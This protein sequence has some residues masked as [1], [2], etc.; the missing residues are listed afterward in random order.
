MFLTGSPIDFVRQHTS[1]L[2]ECECLLF[3]RSTPN[4]ARDFMDFYTPRFL[5]EQGWP[6][7][8]PIRILDV[9]SGGLL[10][11][12]TT[13]TALANEGYLVELILVDNNIHT[14][15]HQNQ[16]EL[17]VLFAKI[18]KE[19]HRHSIKLLGLFSS[20][21]SYLATTRGHHPLQFRQVPKEKISAL[22]AAGTKRRYLSIPLG[23]DVDSHKTLND[24][25]R[26]EFYGSVEACR[27]K[28]PDLVLIVDD[29]TE[30]HPYAVTPIEYREHSKQDPFAFEFE[31]LK[32]LT[33][34]NPDIFLLGT[35]KTAKAT[36]PLNQFEVN[37]VQFQKENNFKSTIIYN[38]RFLNE[39]YLVDEKYRVVY[40]EFLTRTPSATPII[41]VPDTLPVES[42]SYATSSGN[43]PDALLIEAEDIEQ[44]QNL[45]ACPQHID[46]NY[47]FLLTSLSA[48]AAS[49]ALLTLG[50]LILATVIVPPIAPVIIGTALVVTG[51][52]SLGF[53]SNRAFENINRPLLAHEITVPHWG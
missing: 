4:N 53:F 40:Q 18:N 23:A 20:I 48:L 39:D 31:I 9:G 6:K 49:A 37:V 33:S 36:P 19:T 32:P 3:A 21:D 10:Q 12:A 41:S 1:S 38:Y 11:I 14:D 42:T 22:V 27:G 43:D 8:K 44:M 30:F 45:P 28:L 25:F 46:T 2:I 16:Q 52:A 5:E 15:N 13:I 34:L 24:A 47:S 7:E 51:L 17:Q 50:V 35:M 26:K 29:I